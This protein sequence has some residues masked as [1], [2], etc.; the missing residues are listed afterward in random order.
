MHHRV[1]SVLMLELLEVVFTVVPNLGFR[2]NLRGPEIINGAG[3]KNKK[4]A[5]QISSF[6][7][8][9]YDLCFLVNYWI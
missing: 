4:V 3:K 8:P 1:N 7:G 6:C 5:T 2:I 9:L